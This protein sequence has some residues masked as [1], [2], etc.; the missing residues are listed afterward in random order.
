VDQIKKCIKDFYRLD[1][2]DLR[3]ISSGNTT[4]KYLVTT[5]T[6][7]YL[8]RVR[9][10]HLSPD[11]LTKEHKFLTYLSRNQL[12]VPRI[13]P[14]RQG[15]TFH[16]VHGR[17][18]ELQS[19][20]EHNRDLDQV[21]IPVV[22]NQIFNLLGKFHQISSQYPNKIQKPAYYGESL[23]PL[24]P[25]EKYFRGPIQHGIPKYLAASRKLNPEDRSGF[26][27][28]INFFRAYLEKAAADFREKLQAGPV[29]V[30]HNDF[31]GNNILFV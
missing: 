21:E 10:E 23:L 16:K 27:D 31:Y 8:L 18:Y 24:Q 4:E 6:E 26:I 30:N 19:Y 25:E 14:T 2:E 5:S 29:L 1:V 7:N 12:P 22:S 3:K 15:N 9:R 17:L 20:L 28:D 11:M 13:I